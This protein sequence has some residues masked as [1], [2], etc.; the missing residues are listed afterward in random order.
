MVV[1]FFAAW[2]TTE[3]APIHMLWQLAAVVVLV[4]LGALHS[5]PGWLALVITLGSWIGLASSVK[6]ALQTDRAFVDR[7]PRRPRARLGF[8]S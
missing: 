3:L 7:A 4:V 1:G 6:G 8:R 2:S 5:W